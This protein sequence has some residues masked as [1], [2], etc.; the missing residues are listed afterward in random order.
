MKI[1]GDI[2]WIVVNQVFLIEANGPE[3]KVAACL[4]LVGETIYKNDKCHIVLLAN[5]IGLQRVDSEGQVRVGKL[6]VQ[7]MHMI[8]VYNF[9]WPNHHIVDYFELARQKGIKIPPK[10]RL[11]P[12]GV[13]TSP[14]K[15]LH[16][17][18]RWAF[19]TFRLKH[20]DKPLVL[21]DFVVHEIQIAQKRVYATPFNTRTDRLKEEMLAHLQKFHQNKLEQREQSVDDNSVPQSEFISQLDLYDDFMPEE[22]EA[23]AALLDWFND[24]DSMCS[25]FQ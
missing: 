3:R 23:S 12:R 17:L 15:S 6:S 8:G 21:H 10:Q 16:E 9:E 14:A 18:F 5:G 1:R 4:P 13:K 11:A 24:D 2:L 19:T 25:P 22:D 7:C 20:K